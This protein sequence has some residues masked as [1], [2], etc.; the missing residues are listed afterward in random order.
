ML[1]RTPLLLDAPLWVISSFRRWWDAAAVDGEQF[2][3]QTI[4]WAEIL[5]LICSFVFTTK[6]QQKRNTSLR[7]LRL[8]HWVRS[9]RD[10]LQLIGIRMNLSCQSHKRW[11]A[12]DS[13]RLLLLP[14]F[15]N[16]ET[17]LCVLATVIRTCNRAPDPQTITWLCTSTPSFLSFPASLSS[18]FAFPEFPVVTLASLIVPWWVKNRKLVHRMEHKAAEESVIYSG[19]GKAQV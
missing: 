10:K 2:V 11:A 1:C 16:N 14:V 7:V 18:L 13:A 15:S 3:P 8:F 6:Q 17:C 4:Q 5:Q 12:V 19:A 9:C